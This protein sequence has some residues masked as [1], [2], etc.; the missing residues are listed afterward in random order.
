MNYCND[1][2]YFK[3]TQKNQGLCQDET[4]KIYTGSGAVVQ[5]SIYTLSSHHCKNWLSRER[6]KNEPIMAG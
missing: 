1:C 2:F 4:K 5:P 3:R 6:M